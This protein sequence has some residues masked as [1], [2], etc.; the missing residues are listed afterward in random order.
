MSKACL[1]SL[2]G[3]VAALF[4]LLAGLCAAQETQVPL[5]D[6]GNLMQLDRAGAAQMGLFPE[7][8]GFQAARL[9]QASDSSFVLE[10]EYK[11]AGETQRARIP[12]SAS[13]VQALR[14]KISAAIAAH[15]LEARP[16][17][18]G[19]TALLLGTAAI[20]LGYYGWLLPYVLDIDDGGTYAA[21]YLLTSSAGFFGPL[22]LTRNRHVTD[23][24]ATLALYGAT[25]GA[26][27]GV[28][29]DQLF[30]GEYDD[31]QSTGTASLLT[32]LGEYAAGFII[33]DRADFTGGTA[34]AISAGGDF[35]FA[36]G[37]GATGLL[38]I[39]GDRSASATILGGSGL[40]LYGGYL[41]SR[42]QRYTRGDAYVLRAA[43]NLLA[44]DCL[45][46]AVAAV[47]GEGDD[48]E[49]VVIA[50]AMAGELAGIGLGHHLLR[51]KDF[52]T[53]Q[54]V[55][56]NVGEF[57][58]CLFGLGIG[59]LAD[60]HD[61]ETIY[62]SAAG[63]AG[64][65]F[66]TYYLLEGEARTPEQGS[67]LNLEVCPQGLLALARRATNRGDAGDGDSDSVRSG[68]DGIDGTRRSAVPLVRLQYRF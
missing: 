55:L 13:D 42:H 53:G 25:R 18:S 5:D 36:F 67:S 66:V 48:E 20:S 68:N 62:W 47:E 27:H 57:A 44:Y 65:F 29:L 35:G 31:F 8:P 61:E 19:R 54:G 45:A 23:G 46:I 56:V 10:I 3:L 39:D 17:R 52:T 7:Y 4:L 9:W 14:A 33:A 2:L 30:R 16:D 26:V 38:D 59:A 6:A 60:A 22:L 41:L 40:G 43:T 51:G 11:P 37:L 34:E 63:A 64:G 1:C 28:F 15:V 21:T 32:S 24:E 50:S 58:G 49:N 12:K